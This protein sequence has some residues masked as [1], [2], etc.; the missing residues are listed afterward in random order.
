[1]VIGIIGVFLFV[2]AF[3]SFVGRL[4]LIHSICKSTRSDLT[5]SGAVVSGW[6][7][8]FLALGGTMIYYGTIQ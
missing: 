2:W 6:N 4:V 3:F 8:L 5:V 7:L 1:M